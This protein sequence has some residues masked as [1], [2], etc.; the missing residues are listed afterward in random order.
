M[1]RLQHTK[2]GQFTVTIPHELAKAKKWGKGD[3]LV[4]AFN[5]RGSLEL[6]KIGD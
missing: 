1:P 3:L 5:E 2:N 4:F 6:K